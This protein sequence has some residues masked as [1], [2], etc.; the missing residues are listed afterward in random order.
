MGGKLLGLIL[1]II[2]LI[3]IP[4]IGE[5]VYVD[6]A[7]LEN[8]GE[9]EISVIVEIEDPESVDVEL[10]HINDDYYV[11][12]VNEEEFQELL[13]EAIEIRE[14]EILQLML[15]S[16]VPQINA[17]NVQALELGVNLTGTNIGICVIDTGVNSSHEDLQGRVIAE[18]CFCDITDLGSGG[19]CS[20]NTNENSN[21]EDDHSH[22]THVAGIV[23]ANG[24]SITGVA[25]NV[26]IISVKVTNSSGSAYM[27]DITEGIDWCVTNAD[28]Y[29][30]SVI[31]ISLGGGGFY[32]YCDA[33]YPT[34]AT[35]INDAVA[36]DI[37]VTIATGNYWSA[38]PHKIGTPSCIQN[39]TAVGAVDDSDGVYSSYQRNDITDLMAPGLTI[40]SLNYLSGT[41]SKSGTS[42]ATPHVA[43]VIALLKQYFNSSSQSQNVSHLQ[44][45]L[46]NTGLGVYD[47]SN[48]TS[49][50]RVDAYSALINFDI[51]SPTVNLISPSGISGNQS[52][53][54][55]CNGTDF[56]L[57]NVTLQIWNSTALYY[58]VTEDALGTFNSTEFN[59]TLGYDDYNWNCL[60]KDSQN[61]E[62]TAAANFSLSVIQV[63]ST[64]NSPTDGTYSDV[65]VTNFNCSGE[66]SINSE[67][68]NLTFF[69]WNATDLVYNASVE[70][71]G[72]TNSSLFEYNFTVEDD[73]LWNCKAC[74]N[75][76]NSIFADTNFSFGFDETDPF[77]TLLGPAN[78][79]S[80]DSDL[81]EIE[82]TF[83]VSDNS[84]MSNC[85]LIVNDIVNSTN[86]SVVV[87]GS[88]VASFTPGDFNW[89]VNCTDL[90]NNRNY[91]SMRFFDVT[92]VVAGESEDG[93][94]GGGGG[95]GGSSGGGG[96]GETSSIVTYIVG[97][98]S[99]EDPINLSL[100]NENIP[101]SSLVM[102][103]NKEISNVKVSVE[104]L[105][106]L[107]ISS[108]D[109]TVYKFF[110]VGLINFDDSDIIDGEMEF[111]V[112]TSWVSDNGFGKSDVVLMRYNSDWEEL[113]TS[114]LRKENTSYFYKSE[115]PGFSYFAIVV[116]DVDVEES[117]PEEEEEIVTIQEDVQDEEKRS[118][119][120]RTKWTSIAVIVLVAAFIVVGLLLRRKLKH[121]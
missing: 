25:P 44:T 51:T 2:L 63:A 37:P 13:E 121:E 42:M 32:G 39:A 28:A 47:A 75:N 35:A 17:S 99:E 45:V 43:G 9:E 119:S 11:A 50:G 12:E 89:S 101:V 27:S 87:N 78:A 95:G 64:L 55:S 66:S 72:T 83:N 59:T 34:T 18:H 81:Q 115:T 97:S 118:L 114:Y 112:E 7:V 5:E 3:I 92:A 100:Y 49:W 109:G 107:N 21:A 80:Y 68:V 19:C 24:T 54:F 67:L 117:Y 6:V 79:S 86:S 15:S 108:P 103:L 10:E 65:N 16:S 40:T 76:S 91:S 74:E 22:G 88:I 94:G 106:E 77:V 4:V 14:D 20:D 98:A 60:F 84:N 1:I 120:E 41:S 62:G 30:I 96:S 102:N 52:Q 70:V 90:A 110:E 31:T 23:G 53:I 116:P 58:N 82:F 111:N 33:S 26:N 69:L 73:Y 48:D 57:S 8:I 61:N 113:D 104:Y 38:Y 56:D 29:N 36:L 46:N 85:S 105:E 93:N 71:N